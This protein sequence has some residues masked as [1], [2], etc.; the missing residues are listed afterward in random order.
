MR[1]SKIVFLIA[2]LILSGCRYFD[3]K[4]NPYLRNISGVFG[5]RDRKDI[6]NLN[7]RLEDSLLVGKWRLALN[8]SAI[9]GTW[10]SLKML[11]YS[12]EFIFTKNRTF[13]ETEFNEKS[14]IN[15]TRRGEF[16]I[17][18]ERN[19]IEFAFNEKMDTVFA[20]GDTA[21][22][23]TKRVHMLNDSILRIEEFHY[24]YDEKFYDIEE[25][26]RVK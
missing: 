4:E 19:K 22:V 26:R 15:W 11:A 23:I 21:Q 17:T 7:F 8:W 3:K 2:I 6:Y 18:K 9:N 5:E 12:K 16:L 13:H 10:S 1:K 14:I 25:Y 20:L 24:L